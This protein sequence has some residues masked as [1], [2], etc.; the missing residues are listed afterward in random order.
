MTD[1]FDV[2]KRTIQSL[3]SEQFNTANSL[4]G[5]IV[6]NTP[7]MQYCDVEVDIN[8]GRHTFVNIPAHGYPV[9]GSSG[10]IHFHNG[11]FQQPVCDC[12]YRMNPP[13]E[14]VRSMITGSCWNWLNNGNFLF[15]LDGHTVGPLESSVELYEDGYT[16][17]GLA[18]SL[19]D[20][21]SYIETNV[22][23]SRCTSKYFKFQCI[24]RGCGILRV[25][26]HNSDT[27]EVIQ[28]VPDDIGHDYKLWNS[29]QG[30]FGWVYNKEVYNRVNSDETVNEH[31]TI[32]ITNV[33]PEEERIIEG[34]ITKTI[35]IMGVDALLVFSENGGKKF[36]NSEED[37]L[38]HYNLMTGE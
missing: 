13:E 2:F 37:M 10:I 33:S 28:N 19:K 9:I 5:K 34:K 31:I 29:P 36:Y 23:I 38:K 8:G 1:E 15:N 11:N 4:V 32:R 22:D 16:S 14:N 25:E 12:A 3:N 21:G 26:C 7:N 30:R 20:Y 35:P 27:G 6:G 24:Y 18:L 17:D